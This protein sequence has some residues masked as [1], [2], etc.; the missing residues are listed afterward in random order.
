MKFLKADIIAKKVNIDKESNNI[1]NY[2]LIT[3]LKKEAIEA[4]RLD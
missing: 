1:I 2:N 3:V 4:Y